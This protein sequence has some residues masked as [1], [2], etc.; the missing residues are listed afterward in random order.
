MFNRLKSHLWCLTIRH[1]AIIRVAFIAI[2]ECDSHSGREKTSPPFDLKICQVSFDLSG[3]VK[4]LLIGFAGLDVGNLDLCLS[5]LPC[6]QMFVA[7]KLA[8][9]LDVRKE[10]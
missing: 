2:S 3:V 5:T 4:N 8:G 10:C 6:G 7:Q 9:R 1:I